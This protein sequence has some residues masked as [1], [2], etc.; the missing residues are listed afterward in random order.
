VIIHDLK[1]AAIDVE[2]IRGGGAEAEFTV[3]QYGHHGGVTGE[4]ADLTVER[5]GDDRIGLALEKNAFW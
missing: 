2:A 5:G 3:A 1:E 4:N